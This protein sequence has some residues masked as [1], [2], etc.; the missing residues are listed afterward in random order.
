MSTSIHEHGSPA[1]IKPDTTIHTHHPNTR[2]AKPIQGHKLYSKVLAIEPNRLLKNLAGS[3]IGVAQIWMQ[4]L[5]KVAQF[6]M[7]FN[8][9]KFT[10]QFFTESIKCCFFNTS[11]LLATPYFV[12]Q[13]V[14]RNFVCIVLWVSNEIF[15]HSVD[16]AHMPLRQCK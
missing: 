13:N 12:I 2:E 11:V 8:R 14:L 7:P 3:A 15:I 10:C 9:L 5:F 1:E 16:V 6:W 4:I